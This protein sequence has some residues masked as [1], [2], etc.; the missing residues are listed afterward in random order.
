MT[1]TEARQ[2]DD[3]MYMY[4]FDWSCPSFYISFERTFWHGVIMIDT[5]MHTHIYHRDGD[6]VQGL[7]GVP[8]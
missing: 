8:I 3:T 1:V 5:S 4:S 6:R 2:R 7:G